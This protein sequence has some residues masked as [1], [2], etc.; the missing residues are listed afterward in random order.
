MKL[1][2]LGLMWLASFLLLVLSIVGA[3]TAQAMPFG[4]DELGAP[5]FAQP[6]IANQPLDQGFGEFADVFGDG[7]PVAEEMAKKGIPFE[8]IELAWSD[9]HSFSQNDFPS[10]VSKAKH[11]CPLTVKYSKVHFYFSGACEHEL[12]FQLASKLASLVKA[13]C[14][15]ATYVNVPDSKGAVLPLELNES[16]G[17]GS[18]KSKRFAFSFD[19]VEASDSNIEAIKKQFAGAEY[20]LIWSSR[21]NGRWSP[22]DTTP[23]PQRTGFSDGNDIQAHIILA[24]PKG[25]TSLPAGWIYKPLAENHGPSN[26][27]PDPKGGK[28]LFIAPIHV[29]TI[30]LSKSGKALAGFQYYGTYA[31]GGYRYYDLGDRGFELTKKCSGVCDVVAGKKY[32]SVNPSFRDGSYR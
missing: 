29:G 12:N 6:A 9:S 23:R 30:Q 15:T 25:T 1:K 22:N 28:P 17:G 2:G 11:F 26:G 13:A 8:R 4:Q 16:H 7:Y 19:G 3:W 18:P 21:Y 5:K 20:F 27:V 24:Q 10:I 14:P 32:G 31:G